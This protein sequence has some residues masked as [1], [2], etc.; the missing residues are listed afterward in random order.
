MWIFLLG[1]T[2]AWELGECTVLVEIAKQI[3][4][5][6][7]PIYTSSRKGRELFTILQN[8][9]FLSLLLFVFTILVDFGGISW[10]FKFHLPNNQKNLLLF[11][12]SVCSLYILFISI[13][14]EILL[15]I[16]YS[17]LS[18]DFSLS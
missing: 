17:I 9:I 12:I 1:I 11:C 14:S 13:F 18:I 15:G 2:G 7:V 4:K 16:Y 6:I 10:C 3:F 8:L 5:G